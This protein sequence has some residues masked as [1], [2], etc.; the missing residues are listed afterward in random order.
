M[1]SISR[2]RRLGLLA[3]ALALACAPFSLAAELPDP[4]EAGFRQPPASAKPKTFWH[5]MNGNV[6]RDGI[7]RDLEAMER[8]GIGGVMIFDGSTYLPAGPA[9]YLSPRWR[10]LMAHAIHEG[11]RGI[12]LNGSIRYRAQREAREA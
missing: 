6:T 9:G 12:L 4:L 5:W 7:T 2:S 8:V 10:E 11:N 3:V 1:T